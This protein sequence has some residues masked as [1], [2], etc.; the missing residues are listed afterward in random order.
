MP[1][2]WPERPTRGVD[3]TAQDARGEHRTQARCAHEDRARGD[4]LDHGPFVVTHRGAAG[5]LTF[6]DGV[7]EFE[8]RGFESAAGHDLE[9]GGAAV[10]KL[11]VAHVGGRN[12]NGRVHDLQEQRVRI[13][14]PDQLRAHFL[15]PPHAGQVGGQP[16]PGSLALGDLEEE[17]RE[18]V[19]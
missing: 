13:A 11:N 19:R 5:A 15:E 14:V 12:R 8:E 17:N 9:G 18:T 2:T 10:K 3:W 6:V 1:T 7:E 16:L 4:V